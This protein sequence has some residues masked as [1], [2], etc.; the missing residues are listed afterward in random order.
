M[1]TDADFRVRFIAE[2][3]EACR[4][5]QVT[6]TPRE[7]AALLKVDLDA[8]HDLAIHLDP[9]IVRA[10]SLTRSRGLRE[11]EEGVLRS[12]STRPALTSARG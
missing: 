11:G 5:N 2:P 12:G 9:K 3:A 1:I 4:E 7:Q 8:L 10:A 6:L